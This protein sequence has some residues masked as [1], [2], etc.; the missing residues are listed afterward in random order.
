MAKQYLFCGVQQPI[1]PVL[2]IYRR[3]HTPLGV[4]NMFTESWLGYEYIY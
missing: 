1:L 4:M 3:T 2:G